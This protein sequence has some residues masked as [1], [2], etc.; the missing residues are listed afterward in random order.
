MELGHL[1][2]KNNPIAIDSLEQKGCL[3]NQSPVIVHADEQIPVIVWYNT[4]SIDSTGRIYFFEDVYGKFE[5]M[6]RK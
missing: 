2:L 6:R 5:W 4:A 3:R 1:V